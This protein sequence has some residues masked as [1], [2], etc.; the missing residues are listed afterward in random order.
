VVV[1]LCAK[2]REGQGKPYDEQAARRAA[3]RWHNRRKKLGLEKA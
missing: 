1:N 3:R 2:H